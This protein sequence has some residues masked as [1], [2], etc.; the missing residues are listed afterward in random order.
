MSYHVK[1]SKS[2]AIYVNI[3]GSEFRF[4]TS[5][6]SMGRMVFI[7]CDTRLS[8]PAHYA[9][10]AVFHPS[11]PSIMHPP[12]LTSSFPPTFISLVQ[13]S[14][15]P[16]RSS[17]SLFL[18]FN[19]ISFSNASCT[20][21]SASFSRCLTCDISLTF[22]TPSRSTSCMLSSLQAKYAE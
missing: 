19:P 9:C 16:Q 6:G 8:Q 7:H 11:H 2:N 21:L 17:L 20:F 22:P 14:C 3:L 4:I 12:F 18:P 13:T 5:W 10:S 1:M 15:V